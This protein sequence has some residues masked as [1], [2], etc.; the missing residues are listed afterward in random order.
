MTVQDLIDLNEIEMQQKVRNELEVDL[1]VRAE[2]EMLSKLRDIHS[3][4]GVA[5]HLDPKP[6][7]TG[8]GTWL[9]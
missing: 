9:R 2:K 5:L 7:M 4:T 6:P 8:E 1:Q 3:E